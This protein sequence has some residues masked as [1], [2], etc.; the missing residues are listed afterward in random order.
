VR[1]ESL[2]FGATV[3]GK[4]HAREMLP[5]QD[6]WSH[7]HW[8]LGSCVVISDGLG[9]RREASTGAR[10]ACDAVIQ[11]LKQISCEERYPIESIATRI[12]TTW[13]EALPPIRVDD[14]LAT[15]AF[16]MVSHEGRCLLGSIGDSLVTAQLGDE[17]KVLEREIEPPFGNITE[18]LGMP[19][20]SEYWILEEFHCRDQD[21]TVVLATDGIAGDLQQEKLPLWSR[22]IFDEFKDI[23]PAIRWRKM[24]RELRDWPVPGSHDD[25]T[26]AV[27]HQGQHGSSREE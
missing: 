3:R 15:C 6:A 11:V 13:A 18:C 14:A 10:C 23:E 21:L 26:L 24:A 9:S 8:A 17:F 27:L 12:E 4:F 20:S 5:N 7:H 19:R 16:A 1:S 2:I 22:W 25:K